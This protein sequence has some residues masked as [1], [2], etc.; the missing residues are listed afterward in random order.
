MTPDSPV[1]FPPHVKVGLGGEIM[2][3]VTKY[4]EYKNHVLKHWLC[5]KTAHNTD[6]NPRLCARCSVWNQPRL[7]NIPLFELQSAHAASLYR[8]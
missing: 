2:I 6:V 5:M 7:Q 3:S 4:Q 1:M 8:L